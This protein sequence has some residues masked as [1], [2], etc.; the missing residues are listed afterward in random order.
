[1]PDDETRVREAYA[2]RASAGAD[3]RYDISDPANRFLFEHRARS[4]TGLLAEHR[5][6]PDASTRI[7]DIG[8]GNG[9]VL[10]EFVG[11]GAT[12]ANCA[13][14]DLL[15]DRSAAAS[16]RLPDADIR[17]GS[18]RAMPWSDAEFDLALQFT[19][20]SSVLDQNARREIAS[21]TLRVLRPGGAILYYDFIWNPGNRDTRGL[22]LDDLRSLYSKCD[23][24]ARRITLAP[25]ITRALAR[26]S[27]AACAA[28]ETLP[29]VRTHYLALISRGVGATSDERIPDD[30]GVTNRLAD[31]PGPR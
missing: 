17:A 26:W 1:M 10:E 18:A 29:F 3:D 25:P 23:I 24:D 11:L 14:I 4:I 13:G 15:E 5:R 16:E 8:C 2:R 30:T 21:E 7:I 6:L 31:N 9:A 12:V 27:T 19:L 28:L 22:R 20:L